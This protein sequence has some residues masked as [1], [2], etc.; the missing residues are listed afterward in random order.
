[1]GKCPP[2]GYR[3]LEAR[4]CQNET[5]LIGTKVNEEGYIS[6]LGIPFLENASRKRG[7]SGS[8]EENIN[9]LHERGNI[10]PHLH[11]GSGNDQ[12]G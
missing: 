4:V 12:R 10:W 8:S 1:M 3:T 7:Q 2:R 6:N 9:A 5:S 11:R